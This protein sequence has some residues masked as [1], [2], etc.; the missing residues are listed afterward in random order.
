MATYSYSRVFIIY[1]L[2]SA[3]AL[4]RRRRRRGFTRGVSERRFL[5]ADW[6]NSCAREIRRKGSRGEDEKKKK[7]TQ[8]RFAPYVRARASLGQM[9]I[10]HATVWHAQK[11]TEREKEEEK[12]RPRNIRELLPAYK[13]CKSFLLR[14]FFFSFFFFFFFFYIPLCRARKR[15]KSFSAPAA[16]QLLDTIPWKSTT[17]TKSRSYIDVTRL[18]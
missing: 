13:R 11:H 17:S 4:S 1:K 14:R 7:H 16:T 9:K 5:T 3:C 12:V 6:A 2:S 10:R 15:R 8:R 18:W